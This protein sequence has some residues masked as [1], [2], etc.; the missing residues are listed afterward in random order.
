MTAVQ[1]LKRTLIGLSLLGL[2]A[3]ASAQGP[4]QRR[5]GACPRCRASHPV[6]RS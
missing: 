1:H 2:A 3:H 6:A 4:S 5:V